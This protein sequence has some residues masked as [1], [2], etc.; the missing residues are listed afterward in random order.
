MLKAVF[1]WKWESLSLLDRSINDAIQKEK[2][3]CLNVPMMTCP[4]NAILLSCFHYSIIVIIL[5]YAILH[6]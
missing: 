5:K 3:V 6:Q 2:T 1:P 4:W